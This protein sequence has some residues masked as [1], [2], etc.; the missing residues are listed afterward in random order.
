MTIT[1][2]HSAS[3]LRLFPV[4]LTTRD[5]HHRYGMV[6]V[7]DLETYACSTCGFEKPASEFYKNKGRKNGLNTTYCK[8]CTAIYNR[9]ANAKKARADWY[10]RNK[11]ERQQYSRDWKRNNPART[12]LHNARKRSRTD[13]VICTITEADIV[14]PEYCPVFPWIALTH[15]HTTERGQPLPT[16][17]SLDKI[18]PS[19]GYI[20]GNVQVISF[21]ANAMKQ[22][23]TVKELKS[24][25]DWIYATFED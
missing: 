17:A 19:R 14:I 24:F 4:I 2:T 8:T 25:A 20:P 12:L 13:G 10:Q 1:G 7:C 22:N 9:S 21:L 5:I 18:D 6:K 16:A 23:A 3:F 11:D 15:G